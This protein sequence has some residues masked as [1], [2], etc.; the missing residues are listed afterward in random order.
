[1]IDVDGSQLV[2]VFGCGTA[3]VISPVNLIKYRHSVSV[4][5]DRYSTQPL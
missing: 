5:I 4:Q 2:E 3:V 1:M